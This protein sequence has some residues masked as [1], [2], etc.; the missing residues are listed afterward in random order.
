MSELARLTDAEIK[1]IFLNFPRDGCPRCVF[2]EHYAEALLTAPQRDFLLLRAASLILIAK[3]D[4]A[5]AEHA[6]GTSEN[7]LASAFR[8][9][10]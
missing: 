6:R 5:T 8:R 3:Y 1:A 2:L 4:L 9:G 7:R 10:A